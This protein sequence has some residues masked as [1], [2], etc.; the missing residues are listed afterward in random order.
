VQKLYRT[1]VFNIKFSITP[2][3]PALLEGAG[4]EEGVSGKARGR[5]SGPGKTVLGMSVVSQQ[6]VHTQAEPADYVPPP[7]TEVNMIIFAYTTQHLTD[8]REY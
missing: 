5:R 1:L 4:T 6:W 7:Q 3:P 2:A 8:D